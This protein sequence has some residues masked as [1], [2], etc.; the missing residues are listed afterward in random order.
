MFSHGA[1][2]QHLNFDM[3]LLKV[4]NALFEERS[5]T[6]AGRRLGRTQSA[7]SN[8]LKRLRE[9]MDDPLFIRAPEGLVLTPK[10]RQLEEQVHAILRA[11]DRCLAEEE[12]FDPLYATGRCRIGAPDRLSLPVML[13]LLDVLGARA[14]NIA[15]DLISADREGALTLLDADQLDVAVG[16]FRAPPR[17]FRSAR[18]FEEVFV[19]LCRAGHPILARAPVDLATVL[20]YPHLVVSAAADRKAVFDLMLAR[21]GRQRHAKVSVSNF[22]AVPGI[23][24]R[25]DMVGVFTERVAEVLVR[26]FGLRALPLPMEIEPLDHFMVWHNRNHAD[27]QQSWIRERIAEASRADMKNLR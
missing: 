25:S 10:A 21:A 15:V 19:C 9:A 5:V 1:P 26:E 14:P 11:T 18:L 8:S 2:L 3:N 16:W 13:P 23:L 20:S 7:I 4:L 6:R 17:R 12:A 27:P 22:S 24:R